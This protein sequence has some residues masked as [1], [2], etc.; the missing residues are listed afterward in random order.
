VEGR[1]GADQAAALLEGEARLA[2]EDETLV[3]AQDAQ[4]LEIRTGCHR[5]MIARHDR[6]HNPAL[7]AV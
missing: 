4:G 5:G 6:A 3:P 7:A 2:E 1:I